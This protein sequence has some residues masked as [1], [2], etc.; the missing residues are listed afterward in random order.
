MKNIKASLFLVM[1]SLLS[2]D[3]LLAQE[4]YEE[5]C[6]EEEENYSHP[7]DYDHRKIG[8]KNSYIKETEEQFTPG[9]NWAGKREDSFFDALTK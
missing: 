9:A 2:P 4:A 5:S 6:C 7:E 3:L 1:L 8:Y